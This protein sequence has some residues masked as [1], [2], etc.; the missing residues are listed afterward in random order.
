MSDFE[1][2]PS[3]DAQRKS[4]VDEL[5]E[6]TGITRDEVE[7][8]HK[9]FVCKNGL[10]DDFD[11]VFPALFVPNGPNGRI[12]PLCRDRVYPVGSP[13][14]GP[15]SAKITERVPEPTVLERDLNGTANKIANELV[16]EF[17]STL[18]K[19]EPTALAHGFPPAV[20]ALIT[21]AK[22]TPSRVE[23]VLHNFRDAYALAANWK[24]KAFEIVVTGEEQADLI[25]EA[26][27]LYKAIKDERINVE[28]R[29]KIIK[30]APLRE[31]QLIDG[32]ANVYKELIDPIE[33][34]VVTLK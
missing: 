31:G 14:A 19:Y 25:A 18:R 13:E 33:K 20:D 30:E 17:G 2:S 28:K 21:K 8:D 4:E 32:V 22:L 6:R 1:Y 11:V 3:S 27:T 29:R 5:L 9:E 23:E 10:C 16:T 26:K 12:C 7:T 34:Q 15:S 24:A